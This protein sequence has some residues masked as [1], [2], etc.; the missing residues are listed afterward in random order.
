[1]SLLFLIFIIWCCCGGAVVSIH[2]G[3][4]NRPYAFKSCS[5]VQKF[6]NTNPSLSLYCSC[7]FIYNDANETIAI[8][9]VKCL[10]LQ[11]RAL[12]NKKHEK[13][14]KR[15]NLFDKVT[16]NGGVLL[17]IF[18]NGLVMNVSEYYHDDHFLIMVLK[19]VPHNKN[20]K[21]SFK[22]KNDADH[23]NTT[24]KLVFGDITVTGSGLLND[25]D[26]IAV[27]DEAAFEIFKPLSFFVKKDN[28]QYDNKT[29]TFGFLNQLF[30]P[31]VVQGVCKHD[32]GGSVSV[33]VNKSIL[34]VGII[35]GTS[36]DCN[37]TSAKSFFTPLNNLYWLNSSPGGRRVYDILALTHQLNQYEN[38]PTTTN[39]PKETT[40]TSADSRGFFAYK[41]PNKKNLTNHNTSE[42]TTTAGTTPLTTTTATTTTETTTTETTT[43][44]TTEPSTTTTETTTTIEPST[45]T[46]EPAT[47]T[48]E[49]TT[50]TEPSTTTTETTT[51]TTEPSTTTTEPTSLTTTTETTTTETT[52]TTEPSTTKT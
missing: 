32:L 4:S 12:I 49:T 17:N 50:T 2:N 36:F 1:M 48:T 8:S 10:D 40:T 39:K 47:T 19:N 38:E 16:R 3:F 31:Q 20:Q 33:T 44:T 52:T 25:N 23:F 9:S 6:N 43:T 18:Y 13:R 28:V 34:L 24:N 41:N 35:T 15:T 21:I 46:T 7:S 5:L 42:E 22:M 37:N 14:I 26:S 29:N 45:T 11:K 27:N 51:T 30:S